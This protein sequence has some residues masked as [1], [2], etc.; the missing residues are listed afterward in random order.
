LTD[1]EIKN[2]K[3]VFRESRIERVKEDQQGNG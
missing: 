2:L 1:I 3:K